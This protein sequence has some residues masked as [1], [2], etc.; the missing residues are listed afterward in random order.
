MKYEQ[1]LLGLAPVMAAVST[2]A[3]AR[4][5]QYLPIWEEIE[6]NGDIEDLT[7]MQELLSPVLRRFPPTP[8]ETHA[9]RQSRRVV[10]KR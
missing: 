1:E 5:F 4:E 8:G 3:E 10:P 2:R 6:R 7:G 9:A